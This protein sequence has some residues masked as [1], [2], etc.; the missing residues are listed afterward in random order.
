MADV[1]AHGGV[2]DDAAHTARKRGR[3]ALTVERDAGVTRVRGNTHPLRDKLRAHGGSWNARGRCW[4]FAADADLS[5]LPTDVDEGRS[6]RARRSASSVDTHTSGVGTHTSG[7]GTHTPCGGTIPPDATQA[8]A[9]APAPS[10]A[11]AFVCRRE[12]GCRCAEGHAPCDLCRHA[13]CG[14][15]RRVWC[16]CTVSYRC[17]DHAATDPVCVG[18]HD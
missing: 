15:A 11:A 18:T 12:N 6:V 3:D 9:S 8:T 5:F 7:V 2:P 14:A 16:V 13:C 1:R 17:A 4:E 10:A